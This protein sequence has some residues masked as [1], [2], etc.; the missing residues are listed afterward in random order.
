MLTI[1]TWCLPND[2]SEEELNNLH[3]AIVNAV[4]SIPETLI[5]NESGMLNLFPKDMMS[6][7][8][9][10]EIVI[11]ITKVPAN[12]SRPVLIKLAKSI[13]LAVR[14]MLPEARIIE[15]EAVRINE[16]AG[17]YSVIGE[18][19][20]FRQECAEGLHKQFYQNS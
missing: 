9:G 6:Y 13:A 18:E 4:I 20:Q 11:E 5:K 14:K 8:L 19:E 1:K 16:A 2:L 10:N 12:C 17:R 7:G 3:K 15:C